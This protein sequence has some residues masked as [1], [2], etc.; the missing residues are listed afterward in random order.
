VRSQSPRQL[1]LAAEIDRRVPV[2]HE[3]EPPRTHKARVLSLL[4]HD[5]S[6]WRAHEVS[7]RLGISIDLAATLLSKLHR[8]GLLSRVGRGIYRAT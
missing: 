5:R 6:T 7:M 3:L 4:T 1:A 2:P 8:A